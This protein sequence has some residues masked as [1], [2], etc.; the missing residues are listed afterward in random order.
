MKLFKFRPLG[1][2][3]QL[4]RIEDIIENGFFC[5]NFLKFN[6]MNEGVFKITCKNSDDIFSQKQEYK[7]CSFSGKD[8]LQNQLMWGH[9]ANAGMGVVIEIDVDNCSKIKQVE[10]A[11]TFPNDLD[12]VEEILTHKSK[13]WEY[14]KEFRYLSKDSISDNVRIGKIT[15]TYFGTP[16]E[17]LGNFSKI[18]ENHEN[19]K[20]YHKLRYNLKNYL[21][22]M[23][24]DYEDFEF[25][26]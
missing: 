7:I 3:K 8:S 21:D 6:D 17:K 11:T 22:E 4:E 14:E 2:C 18:K 15:K 26:F 1:T 19:L 25:N 9:Y 23:K 10:Y 12:S 13:D 20:K 5:C 16:Y 24:I